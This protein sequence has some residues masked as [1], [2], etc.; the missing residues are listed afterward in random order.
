[1]SYDQYEQ[2]RRSGRPFELYLF[3]YGSEPE[4]QYGVTNAPEPIEYDGVTYEPAPIDREQVTTSGRLDEN[5][6]TITVAR[7]DPLAV[8]LQTYPPSWVISVIIRQ[9]HFPQEP[10][11]SNPQAGEALPVGFVGR[12]MERVGGGGAAVKL[13]CAPSANSIQRVGLRRNYQWS[14]PHALYGHLCQASKEAATSQHE[15]IEISGNRITLLDF[16]VTGRLPQNYIAGL[17][18]WDGQHARE[19]RTILNVANGDRVSLSGPLMGLAVGDTVTVALGCA[20]DLHDCQHVHDN[21]LNYGGHPFI[22]QNNPFYK[23]NHD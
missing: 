3:R 14:C 7:D 17:V 22:P 4:A 21:V 9:G 6:L 19:Y 18:E 12:V 20:H 11:A 23:N 13:I 10:L 16:P 5:E 1:M 8:M 2:S 15:I